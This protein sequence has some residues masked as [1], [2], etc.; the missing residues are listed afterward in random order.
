MSIDFDVFGND[1]GVVIADPSWT[2]HMNLN[3][4]SLKD[5]ELKSLRM[6]KLQR[7]GM[8][9]L[10][11]TG[12]TIETGREFLRGWGYEVVN[13]MTWVKTSQLARTISTG[14]TGHWLNHSKEHLLVAVKGAPR[15]LGRGVD[16]QVLLASTRET[17]R[18]PDEIYGIVE[19]P[20][21]A[22]AA[23]VRKLEIF[24][25]QHNTRP[26]W[27]TVGN[28]LDGVRVADAALWRRWCRWRCSGGAGSSATLP[29]ATLPAANRS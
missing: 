2:I 27:L 12:R 24:G 4:S 25:R 13:E 3:Y 19:R 10:W 8:F 1:F 18:K 21:A 16:A 7:E 15:W 29:V 28:Q 26:G 20:A 11:V 23:G 22:A 5:E 17:S 9:L 14:R 6:D